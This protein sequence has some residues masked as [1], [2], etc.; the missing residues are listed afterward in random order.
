[1]SG[2]LPQNILTP[3]CPQYHQ[4]LNPTYNFPAPFWSI[5]WSGGQGLTKYILKN[6]KNFKNKKILDIGTGCGATSIAFY[7][8]GEGNQIVA[9]DIDVDSIFSCRKNLVDNLDRN[10]AVDS[11]V[12][13]FWG[14]EIF[15]SF[16]S[17]FHQ[18]FS[19]NSFT[20]N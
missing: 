9:N 12:I 16:F 15:F 17:F 19:Q 11:N 7:K 18:L 8:Y 1:M 6:I 14:R 13:G 5:Y 2:P 4:P 10:R 20:V 3:S